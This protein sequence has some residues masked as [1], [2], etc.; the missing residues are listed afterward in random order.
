VK[1]LSLR[2]VEG[3]YEVRTA[4]EVLAVRLAATRADNDLLGQIEE[5]ARLH[6]NAVQRG[7]V[8]E[9]LEYD[10]RFHGLIAEGAD[11]PILAHM[12]TSLADRIHI[13]RRMDLGRW[14]DETSGQEHHEV[15]KA[16]LRRDEE[17]AAHLM[18]SHILEHKGRVLEILGE[19]EAGAGESP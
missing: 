14:Q 8:D 1:R 3:L 18:E 5:A 9:F 11:N 7:A 4:L 15:A 10:R 17:G 19:A 16:L 12:L 6:V 2:E 13:V